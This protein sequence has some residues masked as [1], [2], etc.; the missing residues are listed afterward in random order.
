MKVRCV[1][2]I[3]SSGKEVSYSAWAQ[4]GRVYHVLGLELQPHRSRYRL[5]GD[6]ATPALYSPEMFEVVSSRVPSCWSINSSAPGY[7]DVEPESWS[8]PGFWTDYYNAEPLAVACFEEERV[9]IIA[10]D[11]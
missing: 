10:D 9:R 7:V 4:V 1:K 5:V 6:E 2:L 3:D 11:P 8:R